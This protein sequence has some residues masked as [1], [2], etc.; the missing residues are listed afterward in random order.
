MNLARQAMKRALTAVLPRDRFLVS[1]P[2]SSRRDRSGFCDGRTQAEIALTFDDGPHPE[3]TPAVLDAL[4]SAGW[5]GTFFVIGE[6]VEQ[7]PDLVRRIVDEGHAIGNH[8]YTHSAP[9]ETPTAMFLDELR[10]T[11]D[12]I[13]HLTGTSTTLVRPPL[14][15]LTGGK[16]RGLWTAQQTIT[17]WNVDPKDFAMCAESEAV[18]WV[19]SYGLRTGDI[20]LLH[21]RLP[22][23]A[24]IVRALS[25]TGEETVRSVAVSDWLPASAS[26]GMVLEA[27]HA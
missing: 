8:T 4:A 22:Y 12:L 27:S 20:V 11:H 23:A 16:F 21:D 14:G 1:G 18:T 6:R 25:Q 24:A 10:R 17:L 26:S 7:H 3:W 2:M 9:A 5:K 15:K 13:E 19:R